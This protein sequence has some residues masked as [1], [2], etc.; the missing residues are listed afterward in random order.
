MLDDLIQ[1]ADFLRPYE[2]LERILTRH[3]GREALLA[4]LG[5][6][7]E[8]AIDALLN[9][10]LSYEQTD[11]PSLTGFLEW[12]RADDVEIKRQAEAAGTQ[13]RVMTVHGAK[14][15]EAPLVIL[16][17]CAMRNPPQ[18]DEVLLTPEGWAAWTPL[19]DDMPP[20]LQEA[21]TLQQDKQTAERLRLLYVAMTRAEVWLWVCAA[22]DLGKKGDCWYDLAQAGVGRCKPGNAIFPTGTGLR[23]AV[24]DW[25][26]GNLAAAGAP[27]SGPAA[28]PDWIT[29]PAI[30]PQDPPGPVSPS[31]LGGA[32]ALP[33]DSGPDEASALRRGRQLH[34][35]LEHLPD[36]PAASWHALAPDLLR[37]GEDPAEDAEAEDLLAEATGVLT[38]PDLAFL[39]APETLAEV[40]VSAHL[41]QFGRRM[42]G[43]IDRLVI[44]QDRVLA[45]DFKSNSL[46]P[47]RAEDTP[48]GLLRQMGA[49]AVALSEIFPG[50]QIETALLWTRPAR[51]MPL[52]AALIEA[53]LA[54]ADP[55]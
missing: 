18:P 49:Y 29:R 14:G 55:A 1:K 7:C 37:M 35:L 41:P 42:N 13:L 21:K 54:Q 36:Y 4:R 50:R 5:P 22:G 25:Q 9:E 30:P 31:K 8:E 12:M 34:L 19:A 53:A 48:D 39:F 47:A 44:T 38:N 24:G 15:L 51:L 16:P 3:G 40:D 45:V 11:I 28:L 23:V 46:I 43:T 33:G 20:V 10:A 6:D 32:K 26:A 17:D 52:T 2:L 27:A